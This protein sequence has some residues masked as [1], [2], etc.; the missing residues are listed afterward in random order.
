MYQAAKLTKYLS[1]TAEQSI[2]I[3]QQNPQSSCLT[4]QSNKYVSGSKT[5]KVVLYSRA[6]NTN[7]AAKLTK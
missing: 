4:D 6:I 7:Q 5:H 2:Q 1:D 3:R